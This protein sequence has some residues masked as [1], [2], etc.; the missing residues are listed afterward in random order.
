MVRNIFYL[1]FTVLCFAVAYYF[2]IYIPQRDRNKLETEQQLIQTRDS[3]IQSCLENVGT[4]YSQ[5]WNKQCW[6]LGYKS[7][8]SLPSIYA[9]NIDNT[10]ESLRNECYKRYNY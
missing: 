3:A 9:S 10:S 6:A 5:S 8:C 4:N 2:V 7:G 1:S